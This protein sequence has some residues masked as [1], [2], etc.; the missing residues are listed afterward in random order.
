MNYWLEFGFYGLLAI[1]NALFAIKNIKEWWAGKDSVLLR[2]CFVLNPLG[3][4][5][6]V[7]VT[8]LHLIGT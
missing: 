2:V 6:M 4:I 1:A 5:V 3:A 8:Y 7:L